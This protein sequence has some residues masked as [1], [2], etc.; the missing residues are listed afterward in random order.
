MNEN[1]SLNLK[2]QTVRKMLEK[3]KDMGFGEKSWEEWFEVLFN[4][5]LKENTSDIIE[6]VFQEKREQAP[7]PKKRHKFV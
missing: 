4:K 3:K 2:E 1:F 6:R 5:S 7:K